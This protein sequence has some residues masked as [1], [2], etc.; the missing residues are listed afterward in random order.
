MFE[1][2]DLFLAEGADVYRIPSIIVSGSGAV[3]A[4]CSRRKGGPGDFGHDSD[5]VLRRS[6]DQGRTWVP[7][8]TL[9]TKRGVDIHHGPAL[10]DHTT[11]TLF[12]FCRYW[13]AS[14]DEAGGPQD[15]V[16]RT[17]YPQM[18][19]LGFIDHL[20]CS[21]DEGET[22]CAP[23]PLILPYPD[24][25]V[26]SGTG[27]GN[28]GIQLSDGR[29]LIQGGYALGC[30]EDAERYCC[31]FC[32]DDHGE[33]WH[34][35][36]NSPVAGT[37]REFGLAEMRDG[38][39]Y[40]NFRNQLGHSRVVSHSCDRGETFGVLSFDEAL[41]EPC[42]HAS[43]LRVT[44]PGDTD[45]L[46]FS[47]PATQS[48]EPG[49]K[50]EA[51]RRLTVRASLDEGATWPLSKLVNAGRSAYSDLAACTDGTVFCLY[52]RGDRTPGDMVTCARF[53]LDWLTG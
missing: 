34:L 10:L 17:P 6:L 13:P 42:C 43:I 49:Y 1:Q 36:A 45:F 41:I 16:L 24:S 19:E 40:L 51:R 4:F 29:L 23:K 7:M 38:R 12:K 26:S 48:G 14:G 30:G 20:L 53:T 2:T 47:N 5:V 22:W 35:G 21:E 11:G 37:I 27:N 33:S 52:E 39:I 28:H 3:L 46:L 9:A 50:Q 8:Q 44:G 32:S 15:V 25:A 31:L 18:V